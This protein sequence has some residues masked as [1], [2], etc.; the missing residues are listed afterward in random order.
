MILVMLRDPFS[1]NAVKATSSQSSPRASISSTRQGGS[2]PIAMRAT[3]IAFRFLA[4]NISTSRPPNWPWPFSEATHTA[5]APTRP[6]ASS[7]GTS[8]S[9]I[10][11]NTKPFSDMMRANRIMPTTRCRPWSTGPSDDDAVGLAAVAA[12]VP[13][14]RHDRPN[15]FSGRQITRLIAA[16]SISVPRQP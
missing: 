1:A 16:N 7:R 15:Q 6:A 8:C 5:T 11:P 4:K 3:V 2:T 13:V 14:S 9:E 12:A 10:T